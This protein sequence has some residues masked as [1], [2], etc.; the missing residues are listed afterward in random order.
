MKLSIVLSLSFCLVG[1]A[2]H[3]SISLTQKILLQELKNNHN[4]QNWYV[5]LGHSIAGLTATQADWKDTHGNHSI[6]ELA[7]HLAFWNKRI[8]AAFLGE[9]VPDFNGINEMTF[10]KYDDLQWSESVVH[11][12]SILNKWEHS[13]ERATK[14]QLETWS[15][16]IASMSSHNAYH[17]G[18]IIYIRKLNGWWNNTSDLQ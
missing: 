7:S 5:P 10:K 3:Q 12:E 6:R 17:T 11:L 18:Q 2:S 15:S 9:P 13:L 4:H 8:L 14:Q 1:C 16:E